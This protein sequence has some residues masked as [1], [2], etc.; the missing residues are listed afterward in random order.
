MNTVFSYFLEDMAEA[1]QQVT[2]LGAAEGSAGNISIF[3][4]E[5]TNIPD[6]FL[7]I[8]TIDLPVAAPALEKGWV[9]VTNSGK[10]LRDIHRSPERS[11]SVLQILAGGQ[12][13]T[14]YTNPSLKP[15]SEFVS[16]LAVHQDQVAR[17][18]LTQHA[19]V[20]AQSCY[21][22]FLSNLSPYQDTVSLNQRLLRW[23]P[24]TILVFPHGIGLIPFIVPGTHNIMEETVKALQTHSLV[25]WQKH[26]QVSRSDESAVKAAD[27]IEYAET[28]AHYE[29]LNL[30]LGEPCQG[31]SNNQLMDICDTYQVHQ[32]FFAREN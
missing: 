19:I 16:H 22:T 15:T 28:A 2:N 12:Q 27:Y 20:H 31:I 1:G 17:R 7:E 11:I 23:E 4:K 18:G 8:R 3:T 32:T 30:S 9:L 6:S 21:L 25:V 10:R 26:G 24:E 29:Y 13:A 5:L 14:L